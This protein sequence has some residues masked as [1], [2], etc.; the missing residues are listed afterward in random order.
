MA[1][2]KT[3]HAPAEEEVGTNLSDLQETIDYLRNACGGERGADEML[4]KIAGCMKTAHEQLATSHSP[5]TKDKVMH[6]YNRCIE[7][8]IDEHVPS[9]ALRDRAT[10]IGGVTMLFALLGSALM[11]SGTPAGALM[12]A[13]V[14]A[15]SGAVVEGTVGK[16]IASDRDKGAIVRR[17]LHDGKLDIIIGSRKTGGGLGRL[18]KAI[19]KKE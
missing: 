3:V 11:G 15:I 9:T 6:Q 14:G 5:G 8:G 17:L 4:A 10:I 1:L 7:K 2:E 18:E 12:G 13:I 16:G 19:R